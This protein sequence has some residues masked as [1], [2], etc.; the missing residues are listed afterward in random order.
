MS[1]APTVAHSLASFASF[2]HCS[3][4]VLARL[5]GLTREVSLD[6]GRVLFGEGEA[7][8]HIYVLEQGAAEARR[9]T[10]FGD[11]TVAGFTPGDVVGEVS[12]LDT[13]PRSSSIVTT[14]E[15]RFL[16]VDGASLEPAFDADAA[17][18]VATLRAF[19]LALAAKV[20]AANLVMLEIMAPGTTVPVVP[21]GAPG[22]QV[23]LTDATKRHFLR[24]LGLDERELGLLSGHARAQRFPANALIFSEGDLG[25]ALHVVLEGKVRISRR[26]PGMGEEA[27]AVLGRGEVFGEMALVDDRPRS[28]DAKA[29][30][31]GC[32]VLVLD[33][34]HLERAFAESPQSAR[35]FLT[36]MCRILCRRLRAMTDLL[37][38]WR[39]MAG[40][41]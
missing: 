6:A 27:L 5:A 30:T 31:D 21:G 39:V 7:G 34:E 36:L 17:F 23:D 32:A 37:V 40:F 15:A 14:T 10:P 20:R 2:Q 41:G 3:P 18:A 16:C 26:P 19:W 1:E 8:R 35:Q 4:E 22:E 9:R 29:H 25:D 11:L 33:R 38:A 24:E 28:A 13:L 12:Y